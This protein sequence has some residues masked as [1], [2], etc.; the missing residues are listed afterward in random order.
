MMGGRPYWRGPN[1]GLFSWREPGEGMYMGP[2][3]PDWID[4][5]GWAEHGGQP[6]QGTEQPFQEGRGNRWRSP[7]TPAAP[8]AIRDIGGDWWPVSGSVNYPG[9]DAGPTMPSAMEAY[10]IIRGAGQ[11]LSQWSSPFVGQPAGRASQLAM[12]LAPYLD[13]ISKGAFS[14]NF[15]Q[16]RLGS[17]KAMEAEMSLQ[18][19]Q[20]VVRQQQM[21]Q[22]FGEVFK[23]YELGAYGKD[24]ASA[25]H[26]AEEALAALAHKYGHD[27]LINIMKNN[28]LAGAQGW[29]TW[30]DQKY[31]DM[32]SAY[33]SH[34]KAR[35][36]EKGGDQYFK[37]G[38][39]TGYGGE[40][41]QFT[42]MPLTGPGGVPIQ[43]PDSPSG[44]KTPAVTAD[45]VLKGLA[46]YGLSAS[47]LE[48][49]KSNARGEDL[50]KGL[51]TEREGAL[52]A[53]SRDLQSGISAIASGPGS[54]DEKTAE[55]SKLDSR[56]GERIKGLANYDLDPKEYQI[57]GRERFLDWAKL[58]SGGKYKSTDYD[59]VRQYNNTQG[60]EY[61]TVSRA[62][63]A[64]TGF[65]AVL[66]QLNRFSPNEQIPIQRMIQLAQ[67]G[68]FTTN[69]KYDGLYAALRQYAMESNAVA[70]GTGVPRVTLVEN[71]L[72]YAS[73]H[74]SPSSIRTQMQVDLM[75]A[76]S[77]LRNY[78]QQWRGIKGAEPQPGMQPDTLALFDAYKRMNPHTGEIVDGPPE[79]MIL[80][81]RTPTGRK[82]DDWKPWT[83]E[84]TDFLVRQFNNSTDPN[85]RAKISQMLHG[86][87]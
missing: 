78:N 47:G 73:P 60:K 3:R 69:D 20:A 1:G 6:P 18:S 72:R 74:A 71:L 21:L 54:L 9:V 33:T 16:A 68:I 51:G 28:G 46:K 26:A 37:E 44:P 40:N 77:Q 48:A 59:V 34:S 7:Y 75:A 53:A 29:L 25:S 83:R 82:A 49:A 56:T 86:Q 61:Q 55:I 31:R 43:K 30:E 2:N 24:P 81:K 45:S 10:G 70:S 8:R 41:P 62:N 15:M 85:E 12:Q 57:H 13:M 39:G 4:K 17:I 35:G 80:S 58:A 63:V 36:D 76:D 66:N 84:E 19:E 64:G 87:V 52:D 67:Q 14:R 23:E 32:L 27:H 38:G 50:P 5:P 22:E 65:G 79:A 42:P 11:Q